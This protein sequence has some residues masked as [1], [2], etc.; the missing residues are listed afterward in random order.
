MNDMENESDYPDCSEG[1]LICAWK[2]LKLWMRKARRQL[3]M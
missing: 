1:F 2:D 3:Q